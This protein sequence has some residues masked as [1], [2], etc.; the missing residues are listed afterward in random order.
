MPTLWIQIAFMPTW[1]IHVNV[2]E[3]PQ[4]KIIK[5]VLNSVW[6][7]LCFVW[8]VKL[9][10][11]RDAINWHVLILIIRPQLPNHCRQ[12]DHTFHNLFFPPVQNHSR[13]QSLNYWS[14]TIQTWCQR[15]WHTGAISPASTSPKNTRDKQ[16]KCEHVLSSAPAPTLLAPSPSWTSQ[17]SSTAWHTTLYIFHCTEMRSTLHWW[18]WS[19]LRHPLQRTLPWYIKTLERETCC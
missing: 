19:H 8:A 4:M 12:D 5:D 9:S 2:L 13:W 16:A 10:C 15:P 3:C 14:H 17:N 11:V 18:N 6:R 1:N 7:A